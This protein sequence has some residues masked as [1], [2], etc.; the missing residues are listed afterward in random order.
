M[1]KNSM[2][3]TTIIGYLA[4]DPELRHTASG[5]AVT[6]LR[7]P[8]NYTFKT[9]DEENE[10]TTWHNVSCFGKTAE[11]VAGNLVKGS[12]VAVKAR[13]RPARA[14]QSD[15]HDEPRASIEL[16]AD[17][18]VFMGRRMKDAAAANDDV[19]LGEIPF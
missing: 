17:E 1:F 14:W 8:V 15:G 10:E 12:M 11:V 3:N 16:V 9:G 13:L 4:Q 7:I 6:S 2:S 18:V 5:T 19:D